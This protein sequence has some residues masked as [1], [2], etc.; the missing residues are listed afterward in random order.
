MCNFF[1]KSL[2]P[3]NNDKIVSDILICIWFPFESS[4]WISIYGCK[5]T[6]LPD[7]QLANQIVINSVTWPWTPIARWN[8]ST[9]VFYWKLQ[10][11]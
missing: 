10:L 2:N 6:I 5:L 4:F 1:Q 8:F 11:G 9:Q 3:R 7:T